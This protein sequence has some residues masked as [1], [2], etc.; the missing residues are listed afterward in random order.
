MSSNP[1]AHFDFTPSSGS[2][3][4]TIK[5]PK[6]SEDGA[7]WVT[8]KTE[9]ISAVGAKGLKR[10]LTGVEKQP[11]PPTAPGVDPDADDKY[12]SA[13]DIWE[14]KHDT[15]KSLLY[16]TIPETLKLKI[17]NLKRASEAWKV[18]CD[19]F[20][21]QGDF[22][23]VNILDRMQALHVEDNADPRPILNELEKLKTEYATAGGD[24][25][26]DQYKVIIIG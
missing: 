19:Q 20:D 6:L 10:Y 3:R 24:L 13:V 18:I 8:Y 21:N 5:V 4:G 11:V 9:L 12:E 25:K 17:V 22:V 1:N 2:D 23:Q 14:S 26:D 15:I 7:N 16:Q